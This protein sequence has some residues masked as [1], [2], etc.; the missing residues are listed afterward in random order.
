M[1]KYDPDETRTCYDLAAESYAAAF[2]YELQDKPFDREL[3][4]RFARDLGPGARIA[5]FC[6]GIGHIAEYLRRVGGGH[7]VGID[8]SPAS[9]ETARRL[10]PAVDFLVRD[11]RDTGLEAGS[12]DGACCFY[13]IVHFT[14]EEIAQAAA[15]WARVLRRGG[16]LVLSFHAGTGSLR[17]ESFLDVPGARATWNFLDCDEVLGILRGAGFSIEEA[18]LRWPYEGREHPSK[19]CY[20]LARRL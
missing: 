9:V 11:A 12:L 13:G 16:L 1:Q 20:A 18:V 8:F 5:D 4:S 3:L 6:T 7:L 10:Y 2:A 14:Y 15:E 19:R 17:A